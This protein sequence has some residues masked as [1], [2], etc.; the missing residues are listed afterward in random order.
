MHDQR[1]YNLTL[2]CDE[3]YPDKVRGVGAGLC[4]AHTIHSPP[5]CTLRHESTCRVWQQTVAYVC[6]PPVLCHHAP[7]QVEPSLFPVL[8]NWQRQYTM[9]IILTEL[10]REMAAPHNRKQPQPPEGATFPARPMRR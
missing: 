9:E 4:Q 3:K 5:R 10:R 6:H 8:G 2:E 1:I 7:P